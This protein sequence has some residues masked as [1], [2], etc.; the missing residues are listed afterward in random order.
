MMYITRFKVVGKF[1][2][3]LDMLRYDSCYP[4]TQEAVSKIVVK[5]YPSE[6]KEDAQ[7]TPTI[8]LAYAH[9]E[10]SWRPTEGRWSSFGWSVVKGSISTN[11]V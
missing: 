5:S 1:T 4:A 10:R 3:P 6:S 11:K 2:F 7:E 8:E 9:N